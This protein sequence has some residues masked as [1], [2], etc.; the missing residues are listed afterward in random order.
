MK[1]F[2]I[3]TIEEYG[4][5]VSYCINH[6]INVWRLYWDEREKGDRCYAIHWGNGRCFYSSRKYWETE[7]YDIIVPRF[8]LDGWGNYIITN[9]MT[10]GGEG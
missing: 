5:F 10:E 4:K 1:V 3:S 7:G 8:E 2:L 9:M 6:D